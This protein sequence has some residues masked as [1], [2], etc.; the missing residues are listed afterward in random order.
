MRYI[1]LACLFLTGCG[2]KAQHHEAAQSRY[3]DNLI[4]GNVTGAAP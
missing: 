4:E 3:A 2:S 1:V